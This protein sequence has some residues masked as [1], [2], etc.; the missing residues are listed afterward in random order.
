MP[1]T[2][3]QIAEMDKITGLSSTAPQTSNRGASR[4]A[5]L[6][7][8]VGQNS[9]KDK[10]NAVTGGENKKSIL[11]STLGGIGQGVGGIG[12]T[13]IDYGGR[14]LVEKFGSEEMKQNIAK[15]PKL[16]DQFKQAMGGEENPTAFGAGKLAGEIATLAAPVA[17]VGKLTKGALEAANVG[18]KT[19]KVAQAGVEGAAFTGG[20]SLSEGEAQS[21]SDY[22]INAGINAAFPVAGMVAKSIGESAP[23]R[24]INS[25]IKP[26]QK[27]FAYGKNP[28][29][30]IAKLG[31][32]GNTMEDLIE[33]IKSARQSAGNVIGQ[34]IK[35]VGAPLKL[36]Q[37]KTLSAIDEAINAANRTPRTNQTLLSRLDAVKQDIVDNLNISQN[38]LE[39][40]QQIKG[41][42]GDLTKWT[43]A[44]S[45]DTAVNK[46]L[47]KTYTSVRDQMDESLKKVLPPEQF[48]MY[49]EASD[50]YGN[51]LSAEN[52]A[53]HRENILQRNDLI[54]FGA[55]NAALLTAV[56]TAIASGGTSLPVLLAGAA[57]AGIDKA[58]ATP[59]FKTRLAS[60]LSKLAPKDVSTFFEKVPTAK[61]L[62]NENEVKSF[63][64][65]TLQ[66][67]KNKGMT[68]GFADISEIK[69]AFTRD[70]IG[71]F[72]KEE[73]L[74]NIKDII[75]KP[76]AQED[77]QDIAYHLGNLDKIKN[78]SPIRR[79]MVLEDAANFLKEKGLFDYEGKII[80]A[81]IK[82]IQSIL[83]ETAKVSDELS[84]IPS[85]GME[86]LNDR[87]GS[88]KK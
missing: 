63:I 85:K 8:T 84:G 58:L 61:S 80:D 76:L 29:E 17:T 77:M 25:L 23:A 38:S 47:Q 55:R 59:A 11:E 46:A 19:T 16:Q 1:L 24:I 54:S 88:K 56:T 43:G 66:N 65:E 15:A 86:M 79:E 2:P 69:K 41:L 81:D 44:H 40:A 39:G 30:T 62:F 75:K 70:N 20:Q 12:L 35:S 74:Q 72:S 42:I 10:F 28:G 5:E 36:D 6:E 73:A 18:A 27:D 31:I 52:A 57:G 51:L 50:D 71:R 13:A 67:T 83:N 49:K 53:I 32:T 33:N 9:I 21:G 3:E 60:L 68:G 48:K 14:K 37:V 82:T 26:V 87:V 78:L 45:D 22:A 4:F 7:A 64:G 34:T